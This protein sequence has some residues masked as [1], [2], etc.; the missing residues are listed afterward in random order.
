MPAT[1]SGIP[2]TYRHANFR[3]RLEARWAAF[4][5][6]VGWSWV[7]EPIDADGHIPDFLIRGDEP[8]FVEVGPCV[9]EAEYREKAEK[10]DRMQHGTLVVGAS[11]IAIT[12]AGVIA[13]GLLSEPASG[14]A[15]CLAPSGASRFESDTD[16]DVGPHLDWSAGVWCRD[17]KHRLV[18]AHSHGS[19]R[20]RPYGEWAEMWIGG[21]ATIGLLE[22]LWA[23]AGNAV[24]WRR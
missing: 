17:R 7:Y 24:K 1:R 5:D 20:H 6:L 21:S 23:E 10:A 12:D 16:A 14:W 3:S 15:P 13:A 11:P 9:L 22:R 2:T 4:F 8:F 18:V 19:W